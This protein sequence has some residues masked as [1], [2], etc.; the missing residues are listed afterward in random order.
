MKKQLSSLKQLFDSEG[1]DDDNEI[2]YDRL[3]NPESN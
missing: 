2:D 1:E 3:F